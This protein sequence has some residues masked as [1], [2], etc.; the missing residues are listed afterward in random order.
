[1]KSVLKILIQGYARYEKD[2]LVASPSTVLIKDSGLNLLIDPGANEKLLLESL[3]KEKIKLEDIDI[4]FLTHYHLDHILSIRLFPETQIVSGE[5]IFVNDRMM[6]VSKKI[7]ET[8]LKIVKTPGHSKEHCSILADTDNG[9]IAV[10]GDVFWWMDDEK[11]DTN[12]QSLLRKEDKL[13]YDFIAL[14]KSRR[15][16]LEIADYIIPGHGKMFKINNKL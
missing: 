2:V 12:Y 6:P 10:A 16:L 11:Q 7:P 4:I 1:M 5:G 9:V 13:A 3:S 15:K 8:E 14:Q